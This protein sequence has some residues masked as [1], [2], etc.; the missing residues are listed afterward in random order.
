MGRLLLSN[1]ELPVGVVT[2]ALGAPVLVAL[3]V[4][5]GTR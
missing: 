1:H 4:L 5:R 2:A 3:V